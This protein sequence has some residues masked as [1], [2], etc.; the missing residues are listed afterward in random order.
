MGDPLNG[1]CGYRIF[2]TIED[3]ISLYELK[4]IGSQK[5]HT[6]WSFVT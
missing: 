6:N 4:Q 2:K 3:I 1:T 5:V